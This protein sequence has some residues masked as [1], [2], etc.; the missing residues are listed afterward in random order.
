MQPASA[1]KAKAGRR[2][3]TAALR[4]HEAAAAPVDKTL[5]KGLHLLETLAEAETA[6]GISELATELALN[7]SNVHRL[8]QTLISCG[9]VTKEQGTDRYLLSSKLWRI[10]RRGRPF[11]ALRRLARPA[12][13]RLVEETGETVVFSVLEDDEIVLIDQVETQRPVRVF[14]SVGQSYPV[15]QV[16]MQGTGLTALQLV[17]LASRPPSDVRS[18]IRRVQKQLRKGD[19]FVA[20]ELSKISGI[21]ENG[22]A[23]SRGEWVAGVNAAAVPL[24]DRSGSSIG[25][26]SCFGPA[27]RVTDEK[28]AKLVKMLRSAAAEL[29]RQ[30]SE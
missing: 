25:V 21:H 27:D 14:F 16:L 2:A 30:L 22:F 15:D 3:D 26:L 5:T 28:L 1:R 17:A 13:R 20:Q 12:L 7:K 29:S 10:G 6:R 19:A 18:A 23:L 9:Y 8:L 4:K 24:A 11:D